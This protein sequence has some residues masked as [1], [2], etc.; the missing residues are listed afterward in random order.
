MMESTRTYAMTRNGMVRLK[1]GPC[2]RRGIPAGVHQV[3][4]CTFHARIV[5]T[6]LEALRGPWTCTQQLYRIV[7]QSCKE[8]FEHST[9][10]IEVTWH[11]L[12]DARRLCRAIESQ[13]IG[14]FVWPANGNYADVARAI[15]FFS[16]S[17]L[18]VS[19]SS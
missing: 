15:K 8:G 18:E 1:L 2:D 14:F 10:D 9:F 7:G 12:K 17:D 6:R 13:G 5:S 4:L 19:R 3:E 11:V 16:S